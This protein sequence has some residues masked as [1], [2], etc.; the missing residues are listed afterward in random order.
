[1]VSC[2]VCVSDFYVYERVCFRVCVFLCVPLCLC[3]SWAFSLAL[4]VI[5]VF[6]YYGFLGFI[7]SKYILLVSF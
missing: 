2:F 1:M 4:F 5:F 7:L 3:V 6:P